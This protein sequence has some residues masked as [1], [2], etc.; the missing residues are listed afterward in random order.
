MKSVTGVNQFDVNFMGTYN[1]L[2]GA[3]IG[4]R[5]DIGLLARLRLH[6]KDMFILG[7]A[8]EFAGA[9][10]SSYSSGSHEIMLGIR[11]CKEQKMDEPTLSAAFAVL[12]T[13][14]FLG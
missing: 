3:G 6:L 7:Y 13:I 12:G 5:T 10:M 11:F 4:Y 14:F 9:N 8:Y 2:I 1:N